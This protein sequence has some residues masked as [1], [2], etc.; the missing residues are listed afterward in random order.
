MHEMVSWLFAE[1]RAS[2]RLRNCSGTRS[3]VEW[4]DERGRRRSKR[5]R[6]LTGLNNLMVLR[7]PLTGPGIK[8][9][10]GI[11]GVLL[12]F[13]VEGA[14]SSLIYGRQEGMSPEGN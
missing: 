1:M 8:L 12:V 9:L 10:K 3:V 4:R 11:M 6:L 14:M 7:V 5:A 13:V 2:L